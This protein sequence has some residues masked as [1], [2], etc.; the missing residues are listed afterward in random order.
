MG[1]SKFRD[2][3]NAMLIRGIALL[4][5]ALAAIV[6]LPLGI[7]NGYGWLWAYPL[8]AVGFFLL[9][10][11]AVFG[12]IWLLAKRVDV[13]LEQDGDD[14]HYRKVVELVLDS[15]MP[16]VRMN[17][18]VKGVDKVPQEGRFLLVC[19]HVSDFDPA[20]IM[21]A[22]PG[23][24]L[25]FIAKQ[26][27]KHYFLAGPY[28]HKLQGQFINRENDREALKTIVKCIQILKED[29]GSVA[30]FPEGGIHQDRKFHRFRPG[31]FKIAQ[32]AKMPIVVC[33]LKNSR[34][35]VEN[36][37]KLK[38]TDTE[39]S[40]LTVIWPEEFENVTTVELADRI[41]HIMAEDLGPENVA[42]EEN[43]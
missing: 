39:F 23:R 30:V 26:E 6:G 13:E 11:A 43:A 25:A 24:Q 22:L 1:V 9:Q 32:K 27:V 36:L 18:K 28:M 16:F 31:V 2:G 35:L 34:Y 5:M 12:Y 21:Y 42:Q 19:N 40:V 4:A 15:A 14:P 8:L 33:T 29:K 41:Y 3:G 20:P 17:T 38:K 10:A 7:F 37:L